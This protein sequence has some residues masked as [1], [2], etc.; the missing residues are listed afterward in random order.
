MYFVLNSEPLEQNFEINFGG[1]IVC[2]DDVVNKEN[3]ENEKQTLR[4][5][6]VLSGTSVDGID[7]GVV[8]IFCDVHPSIPKS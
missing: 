6:G 1:H 3:M 4:V 2:Q 8:D 7:V 5:I